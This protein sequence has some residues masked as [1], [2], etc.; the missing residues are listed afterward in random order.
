MSFD[1]EFGLS[2]TF[3]NMEFT[4]E[5]LSSGEVTYDFDFGS[6]VEIHPILNGLSNQHKAIWCD[7]KAS[8]TNGRFY[9]ATQNS[10]TIINN[11]NGQA[12]LEDYYTQ[13]I[14]GRAE[15]TLKSG[16]IVDLNVSF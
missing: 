11:K 7:P 4:A 9:V 10:L 1:F 16:D 12:I 8:L 2:G 14:P 15:E 13:E 5:S 6:G 3:I